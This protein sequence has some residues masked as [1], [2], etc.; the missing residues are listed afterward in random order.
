MKTCTKIVIAFVI[1][2]I[3]AL[4]AF[5]TLKYF[6]G[7]KRSSLTEKDEK[8][9]QNVGKAGSVSPKT[10]LIGAGVISLLFVI[11]LI[12]SA[13]RGQQQSRPVKNIETTINK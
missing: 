5:Y 1:F 8:D 7:N 2:F 13:Q 6:Q 10:M 11:L 9:D 4:S 3:I 12:A